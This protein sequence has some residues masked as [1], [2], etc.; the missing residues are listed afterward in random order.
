[1]VREKRCFRLNRIFCIRGVKTAFF[2][3]SFFILGNSIALGADQYVTP[4]G[5]GAKN[6]GDWANA[7][8]AG[9]LQ[10]A[11]D[12]IGSGDTC[13]IG[14]GTYFNKTLKLK[15]GGTSAAAFK[16]LVGVDTGGGRPVFVGNWELSDPTT[17][18]TFILLENEIDY[19]WF[20]NFEIQNYKIG[21]KSSAAG[22]NSGGQIHNVDMTDVRYGIWFQGG[23]SET[24]PGSS[25][26]TL[27]DCDIA[28]Y[29]K[30]A[31]RFEGGV[32]HV[33]VLN[34]TAD[35]GG[36]DYAVEPFHI[37]FVING[38]EGSIKDHDI[39]FEDCVA[40]NNYHDG[41]TNYWNAD[42]FVAEK[43]S[44]N[45]SYTRCRAFDNTDAGW[46]DKSENP[47]FVDC[48]GFGNKRNFR[49]WT[50][51]GTAQLTNCIGAYAVK[52]GGTGTAAGFWSRGNAV[53]DRCTFHNNPID[54]DLDLDATVTL[55]DSIISLDGAYTSAD[56]FTMEPT[57]VLNKNGVVE[58]IA[59]VLGTDP[60]YVNAT[61]GSWEGGS[62]DFNSTL[63]ETSKG[64]ANDDGEHNS[65]L[66]AQIA[67]PADG[68]TLFGTVPIQVE[69]FAAA[70]IRRVRFY[71]D[72]NVEFG[73]YSAP[74]E[75][76]FDTTLFGDGLHFIRAKVTDQDGTSA[77]SEEFAITIQNA[78]LDI[79]ITAPASG[80]TVSETVLV[81]T[82][83]FANAGIRRVRF[84]ID[85]QLQFGDFTAPY[86]WH[87]DTTQ[88]SNG[89]HQLKAKVTDDD[90]LS[91]S[92]E[93]SV[94]VSN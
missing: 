7:Y 20:E 16:K 3:L 92:A 68:A 89:A 38:G 47:V 85:N 31:F 54:V 88:F 22:N 34:C 27:K 30:H 73:D 28:H 29:T 67:S 36:I 84:Y 37:G 86:E 42:G 66:W 21:I 44:Y 13:F 80:A 25:N 40:R 50:T 71:V 56:L 62:D 24:R 41:G 93:I 52:L 81:Q 61:N 12:N 15:T 53:V 43:N 19:W 83:A 58:W 57:T 87:F 32:S 59:G 8:A 26:I 72:G 64:Y 4:Y 69:A 55:K 33:S 5:A 78:A 90:G 82:D 6:G 76:N 75:W 45:I 35:A 10:T 11:W 14:S 2:L 74:Y 51:T 39:A 65:P 70:G 1:M 79:T 77:F 60:Q 18:K 9:D 91:T 23:A 17:G 46:D 63:Y 49:I 48:I 94:T